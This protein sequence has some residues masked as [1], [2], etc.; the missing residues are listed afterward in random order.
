[1]VIEEKVLYGGL[2]VSVL[3]LTVSTLL[4]IKQ[5]LFIN[6]FVKKSYK[7]ISQSDF[8][9]SDI[10]IP[11]HLFPNEKHIVKEV[12]DIFYEEK[13]KE[14]VK[15]IITDSYNLD[16]IVLNV[17]KLLKKHISISRI[18]V[19]FIDYIDEKIITE[20]SVSD[21][22][23]ILIKAGYK[24]SFNETGLME[25]LESKEGRYYNDLELEL[26]KKPES[27]SLQRI[28]GEGIRSN[29]I[30]P[31]LSDEKVFGLV[32]LSTK[33]YNYF[34][35]RKMDVMTKVIVELSEVLKRSYLVKITLN[36]LLG[37][38]SELIDNKR[39]VEGDHLMKV[40]AYADIIAD[41]IYEHPQ[42]G[43]EIDTKYL[44]E[45]HDYTP[46]HDIGKIILCGQSVGTEQ[47]LDEMHQIVSQSHVTIGSELFSRLR[48][49]LNIFDAHYFETAEE[50]IRYHHE[51]WDGS[52]YPAGI[53]GDN[54]PLAARIVC[55][56]DVFDLLTSYQI[57]NHYFSFKESVAIIQSKASIQFDPY[58][59]KIFMSEINKIHT[60]YLSNRK[61]KMFE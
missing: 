55:I 7:K 57:N 36:H 54:I 43:Y 42:K 26:N 56:V 35:Q 29:M 46:F 23:P 39:L 22:S 31:F 11:K 30:V 58:L 25:I 13:L 8:E 6:R 1:M 12:R 9:F 61:E 47:K 60:V 44:K 27:E 38:V 15:Q 21:T 16:S 28:I 3:L 10:K 19:A 49:S 48:D 4:I 34:S 50:I 59:V 18:G 33:D 32:F 37:S 14:D 45:I 52:G 17:F 20:V 2:L 40:T 41:Y 5:Q 51:S 53:M 24:V